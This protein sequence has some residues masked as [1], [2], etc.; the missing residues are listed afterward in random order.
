MAQIPLIEQARLTL[1]AQVARVLFH[2]FNNFLNGLLLH[3]AVLEREPTQGSHDSIAEIQQ[4]GRRISDLLKQWSRIRTSQPGDVIGVN[5]NEVLQEAAA[6]AC[7]ELAEHGRCVSVETG[8]GRKSGVVLDLDP[9]LRPVA[10]TPIEMT[11]VCLLLVK[12]SIAATTS[13][14]PVILRTR[15]MPAHILLHV[16][17]P[18]VDLPAEH[19]SRLFECL[20]GGNASGYDFLDMAVCKHLVRR[21]RGK[22]RAENRPGG[23]LLVTA[24]LPEFI[25]SECGAKM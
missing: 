25:P 15:Q 5:L 18:A 20:D 12:N 11:Q 8:V 10:A 7:R 1:P 4:Q 6:Q 22:I 23:G 9:Q 17:S 19:M 3:L 13:E 21:C 24:E 2:E 14:S 16:Q